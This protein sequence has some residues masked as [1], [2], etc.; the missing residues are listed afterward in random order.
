MANELITE[1]RTQFQKYWVSYVVML[2]TPLL[3]AMIFGIRMDSFFFEYTFYLIGPLGLPSFSMIDNLS[4]VGWI[5]WG[6][7]MFVLR[8]FIHFVFTIVAQKLGNAN[9]NLLTFLG[10]FFLSF[11]GFVMLNSV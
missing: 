1:V 6:G 4:G 10:Q 7:S 11:C 8:F 3:V 9:I 5:F 2:L